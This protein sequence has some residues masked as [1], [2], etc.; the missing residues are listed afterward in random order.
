M[1]YPTELRG[2]FSLP[3]PVR[4]ASLAREGLR[5]HAR[6]I[7]SFRPVGNGKVASGP[8]VFGRFFRASA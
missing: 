1:L 4:I 3:I 5:D 8:Y 7:E 6:T 2:L